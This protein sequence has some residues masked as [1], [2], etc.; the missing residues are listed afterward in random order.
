MGTAL[1]NFGTRASN[2]GHGPL[3]FC[4]VKAIFSARVPKNLDGPR[5]PQEV[6][7]ARLKRGPRVETRGILAIRV[8]APM[9]DNESEG[10]GVENEL[11]A[12]K[13]LYFSREK[14]MASKNLK[15]SG[16]I[17]IWSNDATDMLIEPRLNRTCGR[18]KLSSSR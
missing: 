7:S 11:W 10:S 15:N 14:K 18:R 3:D 13:I 5:P 12:A 1:L 6:V 9:T 2:I 8:F 4:R 17:R 16:V